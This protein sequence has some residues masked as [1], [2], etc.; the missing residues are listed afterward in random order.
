M[1]RKVLIK[2]HEFITNL[3][4]W[5]LSHLPPMNMNEIL[6]EQYKPEACDIE[7][8]DKCV[9]F[10]RVFFKE[11]ADAQMYQ[12]IQYRLKN[13]SVHQKQELIREIVN[14]VSGIMQ[15]ELTD[16]YFVDDLRSMGL[17]DAQRNCIVFSNAYLQRDDDLCNVEV[18][19]TIFHELKHAVQHKSLTENGNVWGY[20]DDTRLNWMINFMR[21]IEA[22]ENLEM[23]MSQPVELDSFGFE[24]CVIPQPGLG[25]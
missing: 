11:P 5:A 6:S 24:S 17:Y 21:Y 23:Y 20:S 12:R 9:R 1:V 8:R 7:L 4:S 19:K 25:L 14:R 2:T 15:V 13:L 3:F 22:D 10:L 18:I 16:V